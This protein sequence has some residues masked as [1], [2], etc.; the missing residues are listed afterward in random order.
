MREILEGVTGA[1]GATFEIRFREGAA[2][3]Y[4]DPKL[5]EESLPALRRL[6]GEKN[7]VRYPPKMGAEDFSYFQ[8]EIPGFYY[9]LGVG[10][11]AKGIT[12]WIHTPEFDVDEESLIV[13]TRVMTSVLVDYLARHGAE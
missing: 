10:N 12:A 3:T 1:H 11:R 7:V 6:L 5:V 4:N 13:G 2:V 8:R 9:M